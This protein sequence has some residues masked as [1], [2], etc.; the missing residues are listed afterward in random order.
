MD[1][2]GIAAQ[3]ERKKSLYNN[4]WR[5]VLDNPKLLLIAFFAS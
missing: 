4:R 5:H 3:E 2:V 1:P